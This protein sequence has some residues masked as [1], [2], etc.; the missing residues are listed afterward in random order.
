MKPILLKPV[1]LFSAGILSLGAYA[2]A[3]PAN[4]AGEPANLTNPAQQDFSKV[5][6]KTTKVAGNIYMLEG[7]GGNVGICAGDDGVLMIDDQFAGLEPKLRDAIKKISDKPVR[8]LLNTHH[9]GD[10]TGGNEKF[11]ADSTIIA[12]KNVRGRLLEITGSH[13]P[14]PKPGL[15]IITYDEGVTLYL[16]GEEIRCVHYARCHT[17]NDTVV[18]FPKSNVIHMGDLYFAKRVPVIDVRAGGSL[19]GIIAAIDKIIAEV[20]AD[21]KIIPGHGQLSN[22]DELKEYVAFLKDS[23][24][25]VKKGVAE[26]K[27]YD[28]LKAEKV[29]AKY[30]KYGWE[31]R[32]IDNWLEMVVTDVTEDK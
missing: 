10:H 16:N 18:L 4:T 5:E 21:V 23:R 27:N 11:G 29:F 1:L 8:F 25:I 24:E 7:S 9:H 28:K 13:K 6:I 26:G 3:R 32:S 20:P 2:A 12:H 15:P 30:D 17:D 31:F 19:K 22:V 14:M